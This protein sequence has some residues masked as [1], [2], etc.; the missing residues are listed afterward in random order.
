MNRYL[1]YGLRPED[2]EIRRGF[3]DAFARAG[4]SH[5]QFLDALGWYR[6][7]G[8]HLG[9]DPTKLAESFSEFATSKGWQA[10][11][12]DAAVSV[13]DTIREAGPEVVLAT[14][15]AEEDA[16]TI[17]RASELLRTDAAAYWRDGDL[18]EAQ[19]EALERQ[20]AAPPPEPD[21]AAVGDQIERQIA[22]RNVDK[23]AEMLR[24]EPAKYWASPELQRQ[25]HE[26]IAAAIRETPHPV[27]QPAAAPSPPVSPAA[28]PAAPA[29]AKAV[30]S[31]AARRTEI[32]MLMRSANGGA[33]YWRN[34]GVQ[35]EYSQVLARL[36]GEAPPLAP[37][38]VAP[39]T[40]P[41]S[42]PAEAP[43]QDEDAA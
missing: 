29:P 34:P 8:Q 2:E 5:Q 28:A 18:Q 23:F 11:H 19:L 10:D 43:P 27:L 30:V 6:D 14:P 26:A 37:A 38:P 12:L 13:Y 3:R 41:M 22:Q 1:A 35:R 39:E 24:K 17:A 20:Q 25:H 42:T 32:E 4:L 21:R 36:S 33:A 15:T 16:A 7:R 40:V 9:A 31:D